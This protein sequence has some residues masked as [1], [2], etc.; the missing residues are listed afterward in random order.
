[1]KNVDTVIPHQILFKF[2]FILNRNFRAAH[3]NR[4]VQRW[5]QD[6]SHP[7]AKNVLY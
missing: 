7:E 1:M 6:Q 3:R 5:I 4:C 2:L